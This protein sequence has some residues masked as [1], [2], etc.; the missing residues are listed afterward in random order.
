MLHPGCRP[1][2]G[3][4]EFW[5]CLAAEMVGL[6][7]RQSSVAG[8]MFCS[9]L[10]QLPLLLTRF[11]GLLNCMRLSCKLY[12]PHLGP[13][14][15]PQQVVVIQQ[16]VPERLLGQDLC[17]AHIMLW[18]GP[19]W[20]SWGCL[21]NPMLWCLFSHIQEKTTKLFSSP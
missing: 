4:F 14:P 16:V 13:T 10:P 1:R 6:A 19:R 2:Y 21:K 12:S 11:L 3:H 20:G 5:A 17:V 15:N 7:G 18:S 9:L 8:P